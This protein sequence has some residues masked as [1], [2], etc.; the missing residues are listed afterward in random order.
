MRIFLVALC[1]L[2][3]L[4]ASSLLF[5]SLFG[6]IGALGVTTIFIIICG[7]YFYRTMKLLSAIQAMPEGQTVHAEFL[8][9][10]ISEGM[11]L[12]KIIQIAQALG[13]KISTDPAV[14]S[15]EDK[16]HRVTVTF[17]NNKATQIEFT[18]LI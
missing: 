11:S 3:L 18:P 1:A 10:H 7:Y 2:A 17:A 6:W 15:W 13:K 12:T 9:R 16:Q 14:Y 4:V 5:G 8:Y